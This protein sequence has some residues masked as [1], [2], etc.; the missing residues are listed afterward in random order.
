MTGEQAQDSIA[1]TQA[2]WRAIELAVEARNYG[3]PVA[4][5]GRMLEFIGDVTLSASTDRWTALELA[6][7]AR[8]HGDPI[9]QAT[10]II[11][12]ATSDD[13]S[14]QFYADD[15]QQQDKSNP[16]AVQ[17]GHVDLVIHG[18]GNGTSDRINIGRF[19][20]VEDGR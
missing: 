6:V 17:C 1:Q 20:K 4:L 14:Y 15:L 10:K 13:P 19:C 3:E 16:Q 18:T 12:W 7:R 9:E 5:A 8:D 2:R 11:W